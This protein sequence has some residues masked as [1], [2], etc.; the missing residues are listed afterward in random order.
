MRRRS[1]SRYLFFFVLFAIVA[2]YTVGRFWLEER[3][4]APATEASLVPAVVPSG[5]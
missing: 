5:D 1:H 4:H 2:V 3:G